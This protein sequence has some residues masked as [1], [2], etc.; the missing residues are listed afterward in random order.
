MPNQH[1]WSV[2]NLTLYLAA[3]AYFADLTPYMYFDHDTIKPEQNTLH[4]RPQYER[5]SIGWLEAGQPFDT[6]P[7]PDWFADALLDIID[8]PPVNQTRGLH[9]CEFCP[10]GTG[11]I[12]YPRSSRDWLASYEIRVPAEPGVMFA[13]PA[14]IWHYV[15]A[16][17]YRPPTE[18]VEAVRRYDASWSTEPSPW[19]PPDAEGSIQSRTPKDVEIP[20][21]SCSRTFA[22]HYTPGDRG[23]FAP[24]LATR[25]L[26]LQCPDHDG[27]EWEFWDTLR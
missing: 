4:Y 9:D 1:C 19:I 21:P 3:V 17:E 16:H 7:V 23:D 14:L 2:P 18:F 27:K 6:G 12:A 25:Q 20:C 26:R 13:A 10:P 5:L 11:S 15:T 8:G 22:L 24:A